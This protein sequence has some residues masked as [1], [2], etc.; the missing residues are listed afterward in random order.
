MATAETDKRIGWLKD[1]L[2]LA[3][4]DILFLLNCTGKMRQD[5]TDR[6]T[7]L[8]EKYNYRMTLQCSVRVF[9]DKSQ[10]FAILR[11]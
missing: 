6:N 5:T 9:I 7:M 1:W 3:R 11:A 2:M 8:A 4:M 10:S